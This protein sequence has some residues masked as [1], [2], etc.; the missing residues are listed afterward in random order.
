MSYSGYQ[1]TRRVN[2]GVDRTQTSTIPSYAPYTIQLSRRP[3][4]TAPST[5]KLKDL[6]RFFKVLLIVMNF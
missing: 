4:R 2:Q 6:L 1:W 3:L 5:V